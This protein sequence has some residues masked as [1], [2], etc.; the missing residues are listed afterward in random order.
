MVEQQTINAHQWNNITV[1][2]VIFRPTMWEFWSTV[3]AY[4]PFPSTDEIEQRPLKEFLIKFSVLNGQR[5]LT[6]DF[7]T[8]CSSTGLDYNKVKY[9]AHL[10]PEVVKKELGKIT[11]NP[12]YLDKTLILKNSFPV[13]W[14]ILF[15]FVIQVLGGN[16]SST[17]Q[18]NFIQQLLAL[19]LITGTEVDIGEI[20]YSDLVTKLLNKSRLKYVSYLRFISCALKVLLGSEYTQDKKIRFLSPILSNSNFTKDPSKVTDIELTGH[21][22]AGLEASGVLSKK[23][24]RPKSKKP[25][26]ETKV[27]SLKVTE[28]SEQSH[29]VSLGTV[30]DPQDL[31]RDIQLASMGLPSTPDEGTRQSK[32]LPESTP[33]HPKESGGNK[34][35]FDRDITSTTPD[36]GTAKTMSR[37]EGSLRDKDSGGN[38][39]P[40]D[41][42]PIH[43]PVADPSRT[44]AKYQDELEKE[45]NEEEVL[46]AGDDID[47]DIQADDEVRTPSP[48][49]DQPE[50]SHVQESASDSSSP[51]LKKFDN[52]LPPTERQLIK[53]LRKVSRVLLNRITEKQ[54]EQH[55]EVA[56]SYADLKASIDQ[57]YDE[58][59]AHRDQTDKLMEASMRFLDRSSTTIRDLYK[60]LDVITQLLKD[61][62]NVGFDFSALLSTVKDLQAHAL[63][64]EE[65]SASW[66]KSSTNMAWNLG[67]RMTA[68]EIY[69]TALKS[70]VS[71]LRQDTSE[72]KSMMVKIYQDFKGQP[73]ST[74]SGSVTPTLALTHIPTNVE[75]ENATNTATEEPPSHTKGE[76]GDTTMA[77]PI[78]SIHPTIVQLTHDQRITSLISHPES[79]PATSRIDKGKGI[80]TKSDEDPS[81]R[82]VPASTIIRP[83][84]DEPKAVEEA[85]I[86]AMSMPEVIKVVREEAKK[87][88]NDL[89]EAISTNAGE[90]FKKA[91]D[92]EHEV[93]KREHLIV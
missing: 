17:K 62:Y 38:I 10:T 27:T 28:G 46:V 76:T 90:T 6:I 32:P 4:D 78:S 9:V 50:P 49:Q 20:I 56:V 44:G 30:P 74:P 82:L 13:A 66:T 2:N 19:C 63:K 73:S 40:A 70:K 83:D 68:V 92:A 64:Q 54:W 53:Y 21:M 55:K 1:D 5:P 88:E 14:R 79:S 15:T 91:Q 24:K 61:L 75:G 34:H 81:K 48:K 51:D 3:V 47:E 80:A 26:T 65:A 59:I 23:R 7:N 8:F 58:N 52:T 87:L 67:S 45:S 39:P 57:Y 29:S 22:I 31:E 11:I 36:E 77:I 71:S 35:P 89:K 42:E 16:Y 93:L 69:Q 37:P 43:T 86:L 12:S 84:P 25:P 41:M 18:V 85:K 33:T 72:I 60:G